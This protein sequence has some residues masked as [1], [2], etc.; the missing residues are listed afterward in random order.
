MNRLPAY[1]GVWLMLGLPPLE[2]PF[3]PTQM[4]I[5]PSARVNHFTVLWSLP[6]FGPTYLWSCKEGVSTSAE[7]LWNRYDV[8]LLAKTGRWFYLSWDSSISIVTFYGVV[9]GKVIPVLNKLNTTPWRYIGSGG[10]APPLLTPGERA[11]GTHWIGGWV[12]PTTGLE[13]V[14]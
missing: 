5:C 3:V 10:I 8:G 14:E 4:E 6:H 13:T 7:L 12:G 1:C 2:I 9:K 11:P